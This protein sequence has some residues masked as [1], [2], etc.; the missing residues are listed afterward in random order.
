[1]PTFFCFVELLTAHWS[2]HPGNSKLLAIKLVVEPT[3]ETLNVVE[4]RRYNFDAITEHALLLVPFPFASSA[5]QISYQLQ[6]K[7]KTTDVRAYSKTN[8]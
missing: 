6:V 4:E 5:K 1:M 3:R 2:F 7:T 8:G